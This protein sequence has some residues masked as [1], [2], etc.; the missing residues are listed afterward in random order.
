[1]KNYTWVLLFCYLL[2]AAQEIPPIQQYKSK[3]S[4]AGNQN[5]MI[6]Q[7]E[8]GTV[9]TANNKG[10]L[11]FR[12]A[13]WKLNSS[14]NQSIIRSVKVIDEKI[15]VGSYMD[16]GFW[17]R[18]PNGELFYV[19]LA[20]E[21]E[22]DILEDEQFWNIIRYGE[23][24]IFQSLH[25]LIIVDIG[26][27]KYQF[28][29]TSN[30]LL[31][32]YRVGNEIYFQES[33]KGLF[34]VKSGKA[35]L[36]SDDKVLLDNIIIGLYKL[37]G[38]L[39]ILTD[40]SGFFFSEN[41]RLMKWE[42]EG[43]KSFEDYKLY[44][45]LRLSD[46]SFALGSIA[47]GLIWIDAEGKVIMEL[48][49]ANGISNNTILSLF[50]DK[51]QNLWL[52]LDNGIDCINVNSPFLEYNDDIGKIGAVYASARSGNYFY[53]GTNH[54]LYY[55]DINHRE[56]FK[57]IPGTEGQVWNLTSF[58]GDLFC[59][60][61]LGT[62][63]VMGTKATKI[64]NIP[65]TWTFEKHPKSND[66]LLQG[67]YSGIHVIQKVN[68]SWVYKNKLKGFNISSRFFE[69]V[70]D[71][72]LL[73]GHE[74]KGVFRLS[75]TPEFDSVIQAQIDE[76]VEKGINAGLAKFDNKI[77]YFNPDGLF[78]YDK[79]QL[80]FV[81]DSLLSAEIKPEEY[82]TGKMI[83]D[84]N[85]RLWMFSKNRI[86]FLRRD[87][88][89]EQLRFESVF[90]ESNARK[91][92]LG[93]EHVNKYDDSKH[94]IASGIGYLLIDIDKVKNTQPIIAIDKI[95]VK[96]NL[97]NISKIDLLNDFELDYER[98]NIQFFYTA[99]HYQKHQQVKY[100][101]R[102]EGYDTLWSPW[103]E[104]TD[105]SYSNLLRGSY[106]F[107]VRSKIG[108]QMSE[109]SQFD[110]KVKP[111]WHLSRW[112]YVVYILFAISILLI[113]NRLY[114]AFYER[115]R[116]KLNKRNQR[117]LQI[118][119][120]ASQ[121]K[122]MKIRNEQLQNDIEN[123]NREIAIATMSTV[124]RNEFLNKIINELK[125][126]DDHPRIDRLTKMI[127]KNLKGNEDWEFFEKAFNN[128]DKDFLK[129]V[130][131]AHPTLTHN[132][133]RL[134]AFLRL[135]L[136]SKEIAPLLNISVRSVEIKRYRLRKK[137]KLSRDESIIDHFVNL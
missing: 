16:F 87:V 25:R 4:F 38:K 110:F 64:G 127:K 6:S 58:N 17:E 117:K 32:S 107:S 119:E 10:L 60:H 63:H 21:L 70:N 5:W 30:T 24:I 78:R 108:D 111:P 83:D 35:F 113:I 40:K 27:S 129:K 56:D 90:F 37:E 2:G 76:S 103:A 39:L 85:G 55:R 114:D 121:R 77:F 133:L 22:I 105:V 54:G 68:N 44:S 36:I 134:C 80:E 33:G 59:G 124:K 3:I 46:G 82:V 115:E 94:L 101:Y 135:N 28:V 91:N 98:N 61:D 66:L 95:E 112:M 81:K 8:K 128:A 86:H 23:K 15:C 96:D 41:N 122:L 11:Q 62:F 49:K 102:L 50:E 19:S 53:L 52:G 106:V 12:G 97:Q 136:L 131:K 92:V 132:D 109:V 48:N 104:S 125:A 126:L 99:T 69:I 137:M 65:G 9:Y 13:D 57:Q 84:N 72:T 29:P 71:T 1:M 123:K 7:D 34:E 73:V 47:N 89:S 18:M 74:Y 118:N 100:Q 67:N 14:P 26:N 120:L 79:N 93:F 116:Q 75:I 51:N 88:F 20:K 130:K 31:K 43:E 45:S 42:I